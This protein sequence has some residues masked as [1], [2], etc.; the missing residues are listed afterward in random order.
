MT[1]L[2]VP[3]LPPSSQQGLEAR[4]EGL[5]AELDCLLDACD[6]PKTRSYL[7]T[8]SQAVWKATT[9]ARQGL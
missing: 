5:Q 2:L 6:G 8:A 4:L 1:K 3:P 7:R 9:L